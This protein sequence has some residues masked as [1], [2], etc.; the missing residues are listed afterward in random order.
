MRRVCRKGKRARSRLS[1]ATHQEARWELGH[2]AAGR[3]SSTSLSGADCRRRL[4]ATLRRA[5]RPRGARRPPTRHALRRSSTRRNRCRCS[6][7][8]RRGAIRPA[9]HR[10]RPR[11]RAEVRPRR[12]CRGASRRAD[13]CLRG[14]RG[15]LPR[16]AGGGRGAAV[17]RPRARWR[18]QRHARSLRQAGRSSGWRPICNSCCR[19]RG[20]CSARTWRRRRWSGAAPTEEI[21]RALSE[22]TQEQL[23]LL[24][25][26][27][28][29]ASRSP[30]TARRPRSFSTTHWSIRTTDADH[31]HVRRRCSMRRK[32]IRCWC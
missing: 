16:P 2:A 25:R 22:G 29:G 30:T 3:R 15:A 24:V 28:F 19:K 21:W 18:R 5:M 9:P 17:A 14:G 11:R 4:L 13:R 1:G 23:A 7:R 27:G 31:A 32:A 12:R 26:L 8:G 6:F 10:S 20:S